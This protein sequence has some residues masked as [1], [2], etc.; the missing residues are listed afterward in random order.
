MINRYTVPFW[1]PVTAK[2]MRSMS[3]QRLMA[4]VL[5]VAIVG[6][7]PVIGAGAVERAGDRLL[8]RGDT[9]AI[10]FSA[11]DGS[12]L[13]LSQSGRTGSI[14]KSG[15]E[16][17]WHARFQD[18]TEVNAA[19]F[20]SDS[21]ERSFKWKADAGTD[22]LRMTFRGPEVAVA[23]AVRPRAD[24]ADFAAEVSPNE[25]VVLYFALPGRLYF[26]ADDVERFVFPLGGNHSVGV[27]F[28]SAFFGPQD[29][30]VGWHRRTTGPT[31]HIAVYGGPLD[32]R[33][34]EDPP[35]TLQVTGEGS[36]WLSA[37][38]AKRVQGASAVVNRP[39]T[40]EQADL[41]LVDSPNGPYFSACRLG[42]KGLIWRIGGTV[43]MLRERLCKRDVFD[44][45]TAVVDRLSASPP[46]GRGK[47][48]I[49][50]PPRY[51]PTWGWSA[52]ARDW[53]DRL[54]GCRAVA[55]GKARLV[56]LLSPREMM[57][58]M[59]R[60]EFFAI[61]NPYGEGIPVL[62]E[63]G[64]E[65]TAKAIRQYVRAGG[66]W[67][68]VSGYPLYYEL[69]ADRYLKIQ[70]NYP[71]AFADILHLDSRMGSASVYGVQP[72]KW[73]PWEGAKNKA[74]IFV[75][76]RLACGADEQGGYCKRCF[77]TYVKPQDTWHSP[78]VRL[79]VGKPAV[80][81]MQAYCE[82]NDIK[83][84][85]KD[86]MSPELLAK[87]KRS[88]VL[89]YRGSCRDKIAALPSLP[90]PTLLFF[91]DY[92]KGGFDKEYPDH[93]PPRPS[94]GTPEEFR[95]FIRKAHEMGHV[96]M[97]YVN[98][99]WWCDHPRGPT[100]KREGE[101]PLLRRFD[102]KLSYESYGAAKNDGYTVCH[103]HPAVQAANRKT[104][105][106][107]TK[108]YPVTVLFQDQNGARSWRYDMNPASP[109]PYAYF[110]GLIS[111][112]AEDYTKGTPLS[113]E[114]G[115]DR[116]VNYES[117]FSGLS[118][119]IVPLNYT[120]PG[121]RLMKCA[122]PPKTW[123]VFPVAL[124]IAH[125]KTAMIHHF[126]LRVANR[127]ILA[128]TMGIGFSLNYSAHATSSI[129]ED[130]WFKWLD[131]L[132]KSVCARYVGEPLRAFEHDRGPTPTVED[133]GV[134]R[135]TYDQV[136]LIANVGPTRRTENGRDL[137]P[138]G[139]YITGPGLVAANLKSLGRVEFGD[140]GVSF[141]AEGAKRK[142]DVW[143]YARPEQQ[144]CV[145]LPAGMSGDATLTFDQ[146]AVARKSI[147]EGIVSF[148]LPHKPGRKRVAP[149]RPLAG[150]APRDWP[151]E[152]PAIGV[153]NI[154]GMGRGAG[155]AW[156]NALENSRLSKE[157][158]LPVR[159]ITTVEELAAALKAGP[160]RWF[161]IVNP[162]G[163][164]F[165]TAA[166][167]KWRQMVE[168]IRQYVNNGG[169]WWETS[170][171]SLYYAYSPKRDGLQQELVG[172]GG[173]G[174]LGIP[175]GWGEVDEPP[176]S[177][178]VPSPGREWLGE[179]LSAR[180]ERC[181]S[182]VNRGLPRG[183]RDSG[184]VTLAA[185][186]KFDF[187]G[188]YRLH[189]WGWFWRI[190]GFSPNPDVALPV[191]VAAMEYIYTHPPLPV[192]AAGKFRVWHVAVAAVDGN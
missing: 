187:I 79:A 67:F 59:Q 191:A 54:R 17:L 179:D 116:L 140:N 132:Q 2:E 181:A 12:I 72:Q 158:G 185:G 35:T 152:R 64:I 104:V 164:G 52:A 154:A 92:L 29:E 69:H 88:V 137:A 126:I 168:G 77:G 33:E 4:R 19:S 134:L 24:H 63:G 175:V 56:E 100:F 171:Y 182:M 111:Q 58:A 89:S 71:D 45:V 98:P 73:P 87:F 123:T 153:L 94:F 93:L 165:P 115:C 184:H 161:V 189:G 74:A 149:P 120:R 40:R 105:R 62:E 30:P 133:D 28:S 160:R 66:N 192:K 159:D 102:G 86:K 51:G 85:L 13:A 169:C 119:D 177:L 83:R 131:R 148:R 121:L 106:Q 11:A 9:Y 10:A 91:T 173:M 48:G 118:F 103:W 107:F 150:K 84:K 90:V 186:K 180:I 3:I 155:V 60:K 1:P 31:G 7:M 163:E 47:L 27:A 76:G 176:Q 135:A 125:D 117:Q 95:A 46:D 36:K 113:T 43:G 97:P 141:V 68:E 130:E 101:E 8:V 75:P 70:R 26:A 49:L 157:F 172:G 21:V 109:T 124:Y 50:A 114:G 5:L 23:I 6:R 122:Y 190:G 128:W 151:G 142:A 61:L 37:E 32:Q 22:G 127:E 110:D 143:V 156:A 183:H 34:Y 96:V 41:I 162:Y 146:G 44:M 20:S 16:G 15:A 65:P 174:L 178:T 136:K 53:L 147:G 129:A 55:S 144:V 188:G 139:F 138:Y 170:G 145:E 38:L 82:A 81:A 167:G 166:P 78:T 80:H 108:E 39:P 57:D 18:G 25:K 42:G 99:T 112:V 14:F